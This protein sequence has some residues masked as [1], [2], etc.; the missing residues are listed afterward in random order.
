MQF[1]FISVYNL[2]C[3]MSC[4]YQ[5]LREQPGNGLALV[6]PETA[7]SWEQ[8]YQEHDHIRNP[9]SYS[10]LLVQAVM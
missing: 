6:D 4:G 3:F 10:T 7:Q 5:F 1:Y 8:A 2:R 9:F